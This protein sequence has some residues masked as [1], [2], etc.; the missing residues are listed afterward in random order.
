MKL[1]IEELKLILLKNSLPEI[2]KTLNNFDLNSF[3]KFGNNILH[4]YV[5]NDKSVQISAEYIIQ[6]FIRFGIDINAKQLKSPMRTPLQL[7]VI[8]KSKHVFDV[9]LNNGAE[10]NLQDEDGNV[11]L[12]QA[13]IGYRGDDGYFIQ[14]L[15]S[16]GANIDVL[17]NYGVTPKSLSFTIANYD[18]KEFFI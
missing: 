4:Y 11:A 10:V 13:V 1:N 6:L 9:L 5:K 17:N 7:A 14:T 15:I 2:E 16:N 3:D 8:N 18:A 12:F